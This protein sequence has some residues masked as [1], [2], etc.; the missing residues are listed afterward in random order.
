MPPC[1]AA[2]ACV[3]SRDVPRPRPADPAA[4]PTNYTIRFRDS[5]AEK[6]WNVL[7][8]ERTTDVTECWD[9]LAYRAVEDIPRKCKPLVGRFAKSGL[10]QYTVGPKQRVWYTVSGSEVTI[11]EVYRTHPKATE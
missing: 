4:S 10:R 6:S 1:V 9:H 3:P 5:A 2:S 7:A 11:H 8:H